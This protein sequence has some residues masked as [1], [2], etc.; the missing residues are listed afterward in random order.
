M[1]VSNES[2][3]TLLIEAVEVLREKGIRVIRL[4]TRFLPDAFAIIDN[5]V[6]AIEI[7]TDGSPKYSRDSQFDEVITISPHTLLDHSVRVKTYLLSIRLRK[8]GKSYREI[9][10]YLK[11]MGMH[12]GISTLHDWFRGKSRPVGIYFS[13]KKDVDKHRKSEVSQIAN[14][15]KEE[16]TE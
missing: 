4:D 5:R 16:R 15:F 13:Q 11:D 3:E 9:K 1:G 8:E 12:V 7:E 2:H 10:R 14:V 6:V